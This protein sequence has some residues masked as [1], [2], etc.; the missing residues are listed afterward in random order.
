MQVISCKVFQTPAFLKLVKKNLEELVKQD[1]QSVEKLHMLTL[2][3]NPQHPLLTLGAE[4]VCG[5]AG[6]HRRGPD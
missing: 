3:G 1:S 6:R 5:Q 4:L 2:P